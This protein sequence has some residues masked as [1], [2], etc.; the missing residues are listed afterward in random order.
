[1]FIIP[2]KQSQW[3]GIPQI[4]LGF[5]YDYHGLIPVFCPALY[6]C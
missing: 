3:V 2:F 4:L 6:E 5:Q 1:M